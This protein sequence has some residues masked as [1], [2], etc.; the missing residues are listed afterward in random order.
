MPK[1][2][3]LREL[4]EQERGEIARLVKSRTAPVRLAQRARVIQAML[5]NPKLSAA[6]A[7]KLAGY[8][9]SAPGQRWVKRFNERGIEGLEDEPRPGHPRP[10]HPRLHSEQT[11]SKLISLAMQKPRSLGYPYQLWTLERLQIAFEE[12][13]G[14]HLSD[15][16][17]WTWLSEEGLEWKRQQSW[18]HEA[19]KHDPEFVEKRGGIIGAYIVPPP[20]TRVICIDEPCSEP[21]E[22]MGPLAAKTYPGEEWKP[23]PCRATFEP[24]YGCRGKLWV[25]GAFEP[26]TG[27]AELA[28][29]ARRDSAS[30]IKLLERIISEFPA[31]SQRVPSRPLAVD[32][33]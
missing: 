27:Q 25:H 10:G 7:E 3:N 14:V 22:S 2:L 33:G 16:T 6:S 18:F 9:L 17:I 30:H 1:Q 15:S 29:S 26:A 20:C 8:K 31:S 21:A 24:D 5:H 19:A 28:F 23:G 4:S 32:R 12:R 13:E 11:R